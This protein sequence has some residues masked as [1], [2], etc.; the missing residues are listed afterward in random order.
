MLIQ[1]LKVKGFVG[2]STFN[3]HALLQ[4]KLL[5]ISFNNK[6]YEKPAKVEPSG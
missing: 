3:T 5:F 1:G 2:G 6:F 4:S